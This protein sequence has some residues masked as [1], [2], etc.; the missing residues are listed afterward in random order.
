[1]LRGVSLTTRRTR[2]TP[3]ASENGLISQ[4]VRFVELPNP[5]F[6]AACNRAVESS[7]APWVMLL[8]PDV[9]IDEQQLRAIVS[10]V[11]ELS[12]DKT[13]AVSMTTHG[14]THAGIALA[15]GWWFVDATPKYWSQ[16]MGPSGGAGL[17]AR[18]RFLEVGGFLESLFAWGE[19]V[20]L[21]WRLTRRGIGCEV[22]DLRLPHQGGHS[23]AGSRGALQ[24]KVSMLYRNR[25]LVAKRNL[26]R[27]KFLSVLHGLRRLCTCV[28]AEERPAPC[29]SCLTFGLLGRRPAIAEPIAVLGWRRTGTMVRSEGHMYLPLWSSA[30]SATRVWSGLA[31]RSPLTPLDP[32]TFDRS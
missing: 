26:S 21:A 11:H 24:R 2:Q 30:P 18:E 31:G 8:N 22:L 19:D 20:D 32:P 27:P 15:P 17:Y 28:R 9:L 6:A 16:L 3:G 25:T 4:P 5:G 7:N 13:L 12:P 23:H 1:M 29:P 14:T 10:R